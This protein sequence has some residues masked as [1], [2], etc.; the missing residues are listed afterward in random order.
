[1]QEVAVTALTI[2]KAINFLRRLCGDSEWNM[3][4]M[5]KAAAQA[6]RLELG[7]TTSLRAV[8]E[9]RSAL[10]NARLVPLMLAPYRRTSHLRVLKKF[11]LHGQ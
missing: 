7:N 4:G 2:G 10:T 1:M 3:G 9:S 11:L 5:A 8:V 6:T